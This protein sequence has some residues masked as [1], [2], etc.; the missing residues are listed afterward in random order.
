MNPG[1]RL[2]RVMTLP[3]LIDEGLAGRRLPVPADDRLSECSRCCSRPWASTRCSPASRPHAS[4]SSASA[5][6]SVRGPAPSPGSCCVGSGMDGRRARRWRV[7]H[8][9]RRA[10]VGDLLYGVSPFD[11]VTLGLQW[12]FSSDAR[13]SRCSCH[14]FARRGWMPRSRCARS[15]ARFNAASRPFRDDEGKWA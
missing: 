10:L 13:R 8:S 4:A 5:W 6:R 7:R 3:T 11:P 14:F 2:Q 9:A 15:S 12:R 1:S